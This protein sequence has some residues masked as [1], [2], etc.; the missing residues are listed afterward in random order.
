MCRLV[1]WVAD[2]PRTLREVLGDVGVE[3]LR[4]LSTVHSHGWG[5]AWLDGDEIA[6]MRSQSAAFD[7][8]QF[9]EFVDKIETRAGLF[10][11]R[12]G[13]PGFAR[14]PADTHPFVDDDWALIHNGAVGPTDR[15]DEL[16][17][18]DS[19]R[20]PVGTTDSERWFLALRDEIDAGQPLSDAIETVIARAG[21]A[22]LHSSSWNSIILGDGAMSVL[23][24]NDPA[25]MPRD[26]KLWPDELPPALACWP[27]Y[28]DLRW[29]NR[30][31]S[32]VVVSSGIVDDPEGWTMLPNHSLL[33]VPLDA[34]PPR[35]LALR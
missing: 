8:G 29:R 27:P 32:T 21:T 24:H 7:D 2:E 19:A 17:A 11:L 5:A 20:R 15:V 18:P 25:R 34:T 10:H 3:R 13:T 30:D 6:A 31:G 33:T 9:A 1:G 26:I 12:L 35:L 22:G 16:L 23:A 14:G 28:L 4:S